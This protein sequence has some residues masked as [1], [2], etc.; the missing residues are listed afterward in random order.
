MRV[1]ITGANGFIGNHLTRYISSLGHQVIAFLQAGT[2]DALVKA[3]THRTLYG[4]IVDLQSLLPFVRQCDVVF[5]L[6]GYNR[7]WS[8]DPTLFY[9]INVVGAKN[10]ATACR[11]SHIEKLVHVSS[12]VTL[13]ASDSP[14]ARDEEAE[15]NLAGSRFLYA[16]TKKAGEVEM[17]RQAERYGL[18]VVI[19]NPASAI[20]DMDYGP[21]PIGQPI[22]DIYRGFW[23]VYVAGGACFIDVHDLVQGLWLAL[24]KGRCGVRYLLA[25][26]NLSNKAFIS[27]VAEA[28]GQRPPSLKIPKPCLSALA[29]TQEWLASR[30]THKPPRLTIGMSALIGKYLYYDHTRARTEFGFS[31]GSCNAAIERS[32][33]WFRDNGYVSR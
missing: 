5:H 28:A 33:R 13:G 23:P 31:P 26:E 22:V 30:V 25:G 27:R 19:V 14:V 21:T 15:F 3:F 10:A 11:L 17:Q 16:E 18:P 6:A 12:C 24:N 8:R 29:Y 2:S 4:D 9:R 20:G 1:G 7:Y 32:V